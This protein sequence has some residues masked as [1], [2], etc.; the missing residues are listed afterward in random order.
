MKTNNTCQ[1][2]TVLAF[3]GL[4]LASWPRSTAGDSPAV[5]IETRTAWTTSR[6]K[7]SPDPPLPY[8]TERAFPSLK[9]K[10]C[11]DIAKMPGTTLIPLGELPRR[12]GELDS[13]ADIVI[14]C[15]SGVRSGK[16]QRILK[17]M[18]FSR[19]TNLT[20]GILQWSDDVDPT[21]AKY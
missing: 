19:V 2:T 5:G 13:T 6:V 7:G 3:L 20:G 1:L 18:G 11:L 14:H 12:V 17:D 9:F 4:A 16:A 10:Q 8:I 15:R 21:V